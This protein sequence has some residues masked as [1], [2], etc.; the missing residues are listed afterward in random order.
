VPPVSQRSEPSS[1]L[2]V[3]CSSTYSSTPPPEG[4]DPL[5][6]ESAAPPRRRHAVY[7]VLRPRAGAAEPSAGAGR[8]GGAGAGLRRA[9]T[10]GGLGPRGALETG[11]RRLRAPVASTFP[12][13]APAPAAVCRTTALAHHRGPG[14]AAAPAPAPAAEGRGDGLDMILRARR[15]LGT[16]PRAS[17]G[18][19]SASAPSLSAASPPSR[20]SD[21][22]V[23]GPE[24]GR[25]RRL[26]LHA[27][28]RSP[29]MR[30]FC[31][32]AVRART[33]ARP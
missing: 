4:I 9:A 16:R 23:F 5:P 33:L 29:C 26:I 11:G 6:S 30:A 32:E 1:A 28:A 8:G 20:P 22:R 14:A 2:R 12:A 3:H 19:P 13:P 7:E 27:G 15:R 24:W 17:A 31:A 10:I 25:A 18:P 21:S